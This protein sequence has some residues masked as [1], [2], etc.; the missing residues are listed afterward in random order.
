MHVQVLDLSFNFWLIVPTLSPDNA[1]VVH[2]VLEG[3][4]H[5]DTDYCI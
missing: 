3:T 4:Y 1:A 5:K 2:P